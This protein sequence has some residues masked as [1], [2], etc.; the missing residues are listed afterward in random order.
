[1]QT[2]LYVNF[3][4]TKIKGACCRIRKNTRVTLG[5]CRMISIDLLFPINLYI[6]EHFT[7]PTRKAPVEHSK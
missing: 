7:V 3:T 1:M 5:K 2:E 4:N 6:Y